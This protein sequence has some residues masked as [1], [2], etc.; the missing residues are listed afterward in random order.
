ML[1]NR[2][3]ILYTLNQAKIFSYDYRALAHIRDSLNQK[4]HRLSDA[5]R[6]LQ[7][8]SEKLEYAWF[9]EHCMTIV[10]PK[11]PTSRKPKQAYVNEHT[12][13]KQLRESLGLSEAKAREITGL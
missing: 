4:L 3:R 11:A 13:I 9:T 6:N 12:L 10:E 7:Q 1:H 2:Q 5:A 8:E